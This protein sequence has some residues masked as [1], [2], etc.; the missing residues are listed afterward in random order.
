MLLTSLVCCLFNVSL[1]RIRV[2]ICVLDSHVPLPW[3]RKL[4]AVE[5]ETNHDRGDS[6]LASIFRRPNGLTAAHDH[7]LLIERKVEVESSLTLSVAGVHPIGSIAT[8]I[9]KLPND[10]EACH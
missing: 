5:T 6:L 2:L 3:D 8:S 4:N 9:F 1:R 7:P 10:D